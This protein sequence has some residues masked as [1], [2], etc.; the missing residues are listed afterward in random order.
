MNAKNTIHT[1]PVLLKDNSPIPVVLTKVDHTNRY[2]VFAGVERTPR[3]FVLLIVKFTKLSRL[4]DVHV[5]RFAISCTMSIP[6]ILANGA[7]ISF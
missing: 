3:E 1:V 4:H 6:V 5:F 2:Y 7:S